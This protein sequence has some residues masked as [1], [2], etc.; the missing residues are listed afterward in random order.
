VTQQI[1]DAAY[2][3]AGGKLLLSGH[4]QGG[5]RAALASMYLEKT[6]SVKVPTVT[7]AATG[8]ASA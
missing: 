2:A 7:F 5:G 1:V 4:S 8:G 6:H 3:A